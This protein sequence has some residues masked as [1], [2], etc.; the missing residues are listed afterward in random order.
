MRMTTRDFRNRLGGPALDLRNALRRMVIAATDSFLWAL[1][2]F[3]DDAGNVEREEA[4]VF[5]GIGF[6]A[7]PAAGAE[8]P[9]AIVIKVGGQSGHPAVVATRD[10]R[11]LQAYEAA[12]GGVGP[13]EVVVFNEDAAVRLTDE[14]QIHA[15]TP[16]GPVDQLATKADIDALIATVNALIAKFNEHTH[17]VPIVGAAG[18]TASTTPLPPTPADPADPASCT[19]ILRAE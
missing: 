6:Y 18:T 3:E 15:S 8:G 10:E 5:A 14:G 19:Q 17:T 9:E 7:R 4:E 13:G 12:A 1:D 16:G 11:A 2:G